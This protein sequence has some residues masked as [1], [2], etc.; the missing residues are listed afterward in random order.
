MADNTPAPSVLTKAKPTV[1]VKGAEHEYGETLEFHTFQS[2]GGNP[3]DPMDEERFLDYAE[4]YFGK[5]WRLCPPAASTQKHWEFHLLARACQSRT[6]NLREMRQ[7]L[8]ISRNQQLTT[9]SKVNGV[10]VGISATNYEPIIML[11]DE[12]W[13]RTSLGGGIQIYSN[14]DNTDSV[15]FQ[16]VSM[17]AVNGHEIIWAESMLV[18]G[19]ILAAKHALWDRS[20]GDKRTQFL[21]IMAREHLRLKDGLSSAGVAMIPPSNEVK[22]R[23]PAICRPIH[24]NKDY[25]TLH[26]V[27]Q[28]PPM[29]VLE[30]PIDMIE[31]I[32]EFQGW[33]QR[34]NLPLNIAL[35]ATII[36][37]DLKEESD[38]QVEGF[39]GLGNHE[40]A[41]LGK[42]SLSVFVLYFAHMLR[43]VEINHLTAFIHPTRFAAMHYSHDKR[44]KSGSFYEIDPPCNILD[45][46]ALKAK[47]LD[48]TRMRRLYWEI[49][50]RH[51][52][53]HK[54]FRFT[55]I[56]ASM[57][58]TSMV[59]PQ[60]CTHAEK[61][62]SDLHTLCCLHDVRTMGFPDY[63]QVGDMT[64]GLRSVG[65]PQWVFSEMINEP[66]SRLDGDPSTIYWK[67]MPPRGV[68][69]LTGVAKTIGPVFPH[70][71]S[72]CWRDDYITECV[73]RHFGMV[74]FF[75]KNFTI[76]KHL[77]DYIF[78]DIQTK[79]KEL[80][81]VFTY[82]GKKRSAWNF[83]L[84]TL[85]PSWR[86][87]END[88]KSLHEK[89]ELEKVTSGSLKRVAPE[90]PLMPA[91]KRVKLAKRC[92]SIELKTQMLGII[93]CLAVRS[94]DWCPLRHYLESATNPSLN[95][96]R[97]LLSEVQS[98]KSE[99]QETLPA[100][101]AENGQ[102]SLDKVI[103]MCFRA[104][105]LFDRP[106]AKSM[107]YEQQW[108]KYR[109]DFSKVD[110]TTA[111][112]LN[113]LYK[114]RNTDGAF[115][116][117]F[118]MVGPLRD[119]S[120]IKGQVDACTEIECLLE[121]ARTIVKIRTP[122]QYDQ[123]Q[124]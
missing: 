52:Q 108:D 49:R 95:E 27:L 122:S 23:K 6:I 36:Y 28:W 110:K 19:N 64:R 14:L 91:P 113:T 102:G 97:D 33:H 51:P 21:E 68:K 86:G 13:N 8:G 24:E 69:A 15:K 32:E 106:Q 84:E 38:N 58:G 35:A 29:A 54:D 94:L 116:D 53:V 119:S 26:Y 76:S 25:S 44:K 89:G 115:E 63:V 37:F 30:F 9:Q 78:R 17:Q 73:K 2:Q 118:P 42:C 48:E 34:D 50:S 1:R 92:L 16:S 70:L 3:E 66:I 112:I 22:E 98:L 67:P 46:G 93:D 90:E 80:K 111:R 96:A 85:T 40:A 88:L 39:I 99:I 11:K 47:T 41:P 72:G 79:A 81:K 109:E 71:G 45:S 104:A 20:R 77:P 61:P 43:F 65:G 4:E 5:N 82:L 101:D 105:G 75:T 62:T 100:T 114:Y 83:N 56:P 12:S 87:M 123:A 103:R 7:L 59:F 74:E 124:S 18:P 107:D 10:F 120:M 31:A 57:P 55:L 60:D 117:F 121:T